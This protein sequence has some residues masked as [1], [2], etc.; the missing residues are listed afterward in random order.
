MVENRK[1]NPWTWQ[2]AF[3]FS[4]AIETT[5]HTRVLRCAGQA[6]TNASG[7]SMHAGD[8]P[9]QIALAVDNLEAVLKAA[10]MTLAN[11]VR[12]NIYTPDVDGVMPHFGVL[13]QRLA[14]AGVQPAMTLLGVARLFELD[15]M[16]EIEAD[17]VA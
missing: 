11:V 14:G 5:G 10:D 6:S 2:D 9:A 1:I 7:E 13:A 17:A 4:Q 16:I 15:L 8:I 12:L 3:G